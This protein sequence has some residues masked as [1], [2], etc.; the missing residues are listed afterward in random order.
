MPNK[1]CCCFQ[2]G[3]LLLF[4]IPPQETC[5]NPN[6]RQHAMSPRAQCFLSWHIHQLRN[7]CLKQAV[8]KHVEK[9][10][11]LVS[12]GRWS[13]SNLNIQLGFEKL[14]LQTATVNFTN[15]HNRMGRHPNQQNRSAENYQG[16]TVY[17]SCTADLLL[18]IKAQVQV[19]QCQ[20]FLLYFLPVSKNNA[21]DPICNAYL[22]ICMSCLK[23][24]PY[25]INH[26]LDLCSNLYPE[27]TWQ[28]I[29]L[30]K[31]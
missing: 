9:P 29:W 27:R 23:F 16:A 5:P 8:C 15:Q 31:T 30:W 10:R 18:D 17:Y 4:H 7:R 28:P 20:Q 11:L 26:G 19:V 6:W 13:F 3:T 24:G 12:C 1:L 14:A 2:A 25:K 21:P 22:Y